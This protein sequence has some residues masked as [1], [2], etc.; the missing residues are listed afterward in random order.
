M[1]YAIGAIR[2]KDYG[3]WKQAFDQGAALR[4]AFEMKSYRIFQTVDDPNCLVI[5]VEFASAEA[6]GTFLGSAELREAEKGSG[7]VERFDTFD[8]SRFLVE[9]DSGRV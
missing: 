8:T 6:A 3:Q 5:L 7:V 4:K 2:V 1:A 9:A